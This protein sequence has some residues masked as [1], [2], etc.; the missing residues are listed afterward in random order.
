[1]RVLQINAIYGA[2]STGLIV[3]DIHQALIDAGHESM[4][5]HPGKVAD[6]SCEISIGNRPDYTIHAVWTRLFG[7]QGLASRCST[8]TFL[9]KLRKI[10]PDVIHM[11]NIHS[12][13]L[14]Y[15]LLLEYAARDGIPVVITLHDCWF[16]TGKCYHFFDIGCDRYRTGCHDCPKRRRD[17]PSLLADNS[18]RVFALRKELYAGNDLHVVGCSQWITSCA[19]QS[20]LFDHAQF[21]QIYNGVD[22]SVFQPG[23]REDRP[24]TILTMAN[25]WFD[26]ANASARQAVLALLEPSERIVIVGCAPDQMTHDDPRVVTCGYITDREE[27][28]RYY[29]TADVFLNLTFVDTLPTVN[30][31]AAACGTPVVTY[32]S[33]G[34][35]ELVVDG[36]TGYVVEPHELSA[37][38]SALER[39]RTGSIAREACR[40][41][42][43]EH[44]DKAQNYRQYLRL[45]QTC[46]NERGN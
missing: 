39:V 10:Q 7:L 37:L 31:E 21:D 34:S 19:K 45:Y 33:G 13:F 15:K 36:Q 24:F 17:I 32:N 12:N 44:F 30:M 4:V 5:A 22:I 25:K 40:Q 38:C 9:R 46:T 42:A 23:P 28:A 6:S 18:A 11:H 3:R 41:H 27:L 1:M 16:F 43:E 8:K 14:N 2:K 35:G 26:P 20:P 29:A